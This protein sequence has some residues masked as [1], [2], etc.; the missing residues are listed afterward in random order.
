M[1]EMQWAVQ[2]WRILIL[3]KER[4]VMT[5]ERRCLKRKNKGS[6]R[7]QTEDEI[8][9]RVRAIYTVLEKKFTEEQLTLHAVARALKRET[10]VSWL[11]ALGHAR[12]HIQRFSRKT[13]RM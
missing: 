8:R 7:I 6:L 2:K 11:T 12:M 4:L 5:T 13:R 9:Q 10:G 3:H 1:L